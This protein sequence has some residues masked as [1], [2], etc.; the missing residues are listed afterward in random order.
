LSVDQAIAKLDAAGTANAS[1]NDMAR[2]WKHPQLAARGRWTKVET[3]VG[4]IPAL[5]PPGMDE[6]RMDPVPSLGQHTAQIL[7]E[8]GY[9]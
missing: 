4:P 9:S 1:V 6:A 2:L 5:L 3:A 8:L 7:A